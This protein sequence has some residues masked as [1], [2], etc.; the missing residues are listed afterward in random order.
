MQKLEKSRSASKTPAR[1]YSIGQLA[2]QA[3]CSVQII[4]HYETIGLL[5][6]SQRTA[7]GQRR[8]NDAH[9]R[10]LTFLRH[11]R[12]LGFSLDQIRDLLRLSDDPDGSCADADRIASEHLQDVTQRIASLTAMKEELERMLDH[13]CSGKIMDCRVV[14][15]LSDHAHCL[16]HKH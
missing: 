7:G 5:E 15:V 10:R 12:D 2:K 9:Q 1:E 14:E 3:G 13:S 11:S 4:R 16:H 6:E 8:Y